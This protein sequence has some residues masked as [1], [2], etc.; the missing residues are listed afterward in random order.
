MALCQGNIQGYI[1]TLEDFE[2]RLDTIGSTNTSTIVW[3]AGA[4]NLGNVGCASVNEGTFNFTVDEA[5]GILACTTD[6]GDDDNCF[7]FTGTGSP[8]VNGTMIIESRSKFNSATLGALFTGF[9][10]VLAMDTPVVPMEFA[11]ATMTYNGTGQI[12][13]VLLDTDA[14]TD[15]FRASAGT[16]AAVTGTNRATNASLASAGVRAN[17]TITADEWYI[18]RVELDQSGWGRVY[19]GHKGRG[20]DQILVVSGLATSTQLFATTG[21]EN[22][23]AAARLW[24]VDYFYSRWGRDWE[25]T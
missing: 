20:L 5:N 22:R 14:T 12:L 7:L 2:R 18:T 8:D 25:V 11:T 24:E 9:T 17:E 1:E 15:D 23:S 10:S 6:S 3:G 4:F 13:G 19:V 21:F 16:N